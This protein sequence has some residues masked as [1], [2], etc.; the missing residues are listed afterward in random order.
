VFL[1]LLKRF[2]AAG[3]KVS[4]KPT[5]PN[6]TPR[7]FLMEEEAKK[8]NLRKADFEAAMRRLFANGKIVVECSSSCGLIMKAKA[9]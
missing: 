3:R 9:A 6:Y 4:E 5:S 7:L 2:A 1:D 8:T